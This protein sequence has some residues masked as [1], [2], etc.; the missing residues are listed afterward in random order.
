MFE[1]VAIRGCAF[2]WAKAVQ[3][4]AKQLKVPAAVRDDAKLCKTLQRVQHL[5]W[6]PASHIPDAFGKLEE[7]SRRCGVDHPLPS[8]MDYVKRQWVQSMTF[9]PSSWAQF[10]VQTRTNN[11]LEGWHRA[12]NAY[13][14]P[15]PHLYAFLQKV[16]K[17]AETTRDLV[18]VEDFTRRSSVKQSQREERIAKLQDKYMDRDIT[19]GAYLDA[20]RHVYIA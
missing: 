19:P 18:T 11:D 17:D 1:G 8:F 20:I 10:G 12:L 6:L 7:S 3:G 16:A 13:L 4:K 5:Q 15:R 9:P 14:G 2:H